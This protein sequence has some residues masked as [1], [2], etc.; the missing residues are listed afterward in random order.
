[1]VDVIVKELSKLSDAHGDEVDGEPQRMTV[2]LVTGD[3][4]LVHRCKAAA[5]AAGREH[6]ILHTFCTHALDPCLIPRA[7]G[8]RRKGGGGCGFVKYRRGRPKERG[9]TVETNGT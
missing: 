5:T 1:M 9:P 6:V 4:E 8:A 7:H 3:R 2:H